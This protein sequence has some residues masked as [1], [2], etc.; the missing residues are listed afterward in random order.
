MLVSFILRTVLFLFF[1]F[2]TIFYMNQKLVR[3]FISY[4]HEYIV[5]GINPVLVIQII[6]F[7]IY[8]FHFTQ[9]KKN[10]RVIISN[11]NNR[12]RSG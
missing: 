2:R 11:S 5:K 4:R 8:H 9:R 1:L 12:P 3:S 7:I 10:V 6:R